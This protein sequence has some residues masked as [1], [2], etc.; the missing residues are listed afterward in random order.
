MYVLF[1]PRIDSDGLLPPPKAAFASLPF[2]DSSSEDFPHAGGLRAE[3]SAAPET[4]KP[5]KPE[6]TSPGNPKPVPK[7]RPDPERQSYLSFLYF[8]FTSPV[9]TLRGSGSIELPCTVITSRP[10][11]EFE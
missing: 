7:P 3:T 8:I 11:T 2:P 6:T 9:L 4:V 5:R 1:G 10:S